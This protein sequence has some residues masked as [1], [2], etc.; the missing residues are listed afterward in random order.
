MTF[1]LALAVALS[2]AAGALWRETVWRSTVG[3]TVARL[4]EDRDPPSPV[5]DLE[6]IRRR[7]QEFDRRTRN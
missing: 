3:R 1:T 5:L 7:R 4:T 2:F 6:E